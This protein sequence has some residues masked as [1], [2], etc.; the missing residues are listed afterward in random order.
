MLE[1]LTLNE[2]MIKK[3]QPNELKTEILKYHSKM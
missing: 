1:K 3:K 2:Q